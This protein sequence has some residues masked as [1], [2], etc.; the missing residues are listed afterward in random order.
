MT[1]AFWV[2]ALFLSAAQAQAVDGVYVEAGA[3]NSIEVARVGMLWNWNRSWAGEGDW[4][5]TGCWEA[6]LGRWSGQKAGS[7]NQTVTEI[8]VTPVF[9]LE[10]KEVS[11][12]APYLE[13]GFIGLHLI[14]PT[15]IYTERRFGT[16]FQFG[17]HVGIGMHFGGRHQFDLAY[18]IQHMSNGGIK[19]PNNGINFSEIHFAY[20]F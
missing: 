4:R 18:R 19:Q 17:N 20:Y 2:I 5:V 7:D 8:G 15:F 6:S 1:R 16:A 3:G 14:S 11:G 10:R 9:R 13:G 12:M